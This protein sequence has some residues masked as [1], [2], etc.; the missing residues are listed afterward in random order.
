MVSYKTEVLLDNSLNQANNSIKNWEEYLDSIGDEIFNDCSNSLKATYEDE[1]FGTIDVEVCLKKY[2]VFDYDGLVCIKIAFSIEKFSKKDKEEEQYQAINN[3]KQF[4]SFIKS[5][6]EKFVN[7]LNSEIMIEHTIKE[8]LIFSSGRLYME[9]ASYNN[10]HVPEFKK[11]RIF[12]E[13]NEEDI[14]DNLCI[15]YGGA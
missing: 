10:K 3:N 2:F 13:I 5:L 11:L 1:E 15:E 8:D 12:P 4:I 7:T 6:V 14:N 9:I